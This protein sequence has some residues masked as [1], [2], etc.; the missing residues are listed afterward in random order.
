MKMQR[1]TLPIDRLSGG[2]AYIVEHALART[3]GVV[4]VYVNSAMEMAYIVYDPTQSDLHRLV[5]AV[6]HA[7]FEA[8]TPGIR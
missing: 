8:G 6:K 4:Y 2:G 7:G 1:I 3:P 5:A